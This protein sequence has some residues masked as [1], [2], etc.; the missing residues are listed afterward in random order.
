MT[1]GRQ[2]IW[3]GLTGD[4]AAPSAVVKAIQ[5]T[6]RDAI[7]RGSGGANS[8]FSPAVRVLLSVVLRRLT[9]YQAPP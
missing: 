5:S 1:I 4:A 3:H 7:L 6:G 8:A 9:P 2:K